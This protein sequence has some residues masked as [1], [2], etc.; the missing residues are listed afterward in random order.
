MTT[1]HDAVRQ[2]LEELAAA[3]QARDPR[4]ALRLFADEIVFVGTGPDELRFGHAAL[5]EQVD[6]DLSQADK[7]DAQVGD[8]GVSGPGSGNL[9]WF[10]AHLTLDVVAGG[11]SVTMPMRVTGVATDDGD[12]WQFRQTHFSL[13]AVDQAEGDSFPAS[14]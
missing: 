9:A 11:A 14:R 10:Y 8:L 13:P 2:L 5:K 7:L 6:R 12:G 1:T 4:R 3:Y